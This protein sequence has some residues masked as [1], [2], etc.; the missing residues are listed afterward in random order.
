MEVWKTIARDTADEVMRVY[1]LDSL[2]RLPEEFS[3]VQEIVLGAIRKGVEE[4][5]RMGLGDC[6]LSDKEWRK[7]TR[8]IQQQLDDT[9]YLTFRRVINHYN[10]RIAMLTTDNEAYA[11][12]YERGI[13][14][15]KRRC[16]E[17]LEE[18]SDDVAVHTLK[19]VSISA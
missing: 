5:V 6:P 10:A 18:V 9:P 11:T 19:E 14:E 12:G 8:I 16:C 3:D 7:W 1:A 17:V 2:D 4:F 15:G 13:A